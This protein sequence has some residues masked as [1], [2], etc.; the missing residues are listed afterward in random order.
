MIIVCQTDLLGGR[1]GPL[2]L[3]GRDG[4]DLTLYA[5]GSYTSARLLGDEIAPA[6]IT[7]EGAG[8]NGDDVPYSPRWTVQGAADYVIP[9]GENLEL[10]THADV[11]Y[12]SSVWTQLAHDNPYLHMIPGHELTGLRA[13]VQSQN[14]RWGAYLFV[15]NLF[16]EIGLLSKASSA[17]TGGMVTVVST[18]PRT[19]G[20]SVRMKL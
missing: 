1:A 2:R 3:I 5:S 9:I 19:V 20:V 18:M 13:G 6:G 17:S 12:Q 16:N 8:H 15:S 11:S 14:D 10:L 7:I 4:D